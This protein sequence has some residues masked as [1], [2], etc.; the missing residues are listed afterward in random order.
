MKM[1]WDE[2]EKH[3]GKHPNGTITASALWA[4]RVETFLRIKEVEKSM[5]NSNQSRNEEFISRIFDY[6]EAKDVDPLRFEEMRAAARMMARAVLTN[7]GADRQE[8]LMKSIEHIR[9]AL[10]FAISSVVIPE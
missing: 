2:I 9:L 10:Y 5:E 7:G 1:D 8:D 3:C 4:Q 6:H